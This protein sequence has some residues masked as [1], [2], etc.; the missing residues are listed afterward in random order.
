MLVPLAGLWVVSSNFT[1]LVMV[2]LFAGFAWSGFELITILSFFDTTDE[3]TRARVLS[4]FHLFNGVASVGASLIGGAILR[5]FGA[6]GYMYIFVTSSLLRLAVV[7]LFN[8][9]AGNRRPGEH[10][11][12]NVFLRVISFRP[13]QGPDLRPVVIDELPPPRLD[14]PLWVAC[15]R[16]RVSEPAAA[17]LPFGPRRV[18]R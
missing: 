5:H 3:G 6:A 7:L 17:E 4:L 11:F 13:G 15:A 1:Y 8:S 2:Q 12:Q 9:G 16:R 10:T 18:E 14:S